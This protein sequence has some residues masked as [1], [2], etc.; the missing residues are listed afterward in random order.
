MKILEVPNRVSI[1]FEEEDL[2]MTDGE[3]THKDMCTF[4][5]GPY[6]THVG[7][8]HMATWK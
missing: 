2:V 7:L 3:M 6:T 8:V 5:P 4:V 1:V